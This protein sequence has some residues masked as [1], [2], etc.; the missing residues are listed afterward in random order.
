MQT[1]A[2]PRK[3]KP[4]GDCFEANCKM[5]LGLQA[6][7]PDAVLVHAEVAGQGPLKG[8]RFG[9]A[10]VQAGDTVY[11]NTNGRGVVMSAL[12]YRAIGNVDWIGN[13]HTY[14][15]DEAIAKVVE[16][17]HYGPWDLVTSTGL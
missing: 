2:K 5:L 7:M 9:H 8:V 6:M 10:F 3:R 11:D 17:G 14:T 1:M 4:T 15:V 13:T 12:L 16:H